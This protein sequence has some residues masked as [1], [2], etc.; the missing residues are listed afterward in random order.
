M[1]CINVLFSIEDL[2]TYIRD[3]VFFTTLDVL[4]IS[5]IPSQLLLPYMLIQH[6]TALEY[7]LY[8]HP[9]PVRVLLAIKVMLV[10][11][12]TQVPY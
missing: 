12:A 7:K 10:N 8:H 2:H 11:L 4:L 3:S 6:I 5:H 1:L 9:P